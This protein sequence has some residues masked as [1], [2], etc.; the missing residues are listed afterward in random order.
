[1]LDTVAAV[2]TLKGFHA[3]NLNGSN[4]CMQGTHLTKAKTST[5][6]SQRTMFSFLHRLG[7]LELQ[8]YKRYAACCLGAVLS[9]PPG[10]ASVKLLSPR[11]PASL[12]TYL[13]HLDDS[14]DGSR[15]F[16]Y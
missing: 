3:C 8:D 15:L 10:W 14:N 13:E 5:C 2:L 1:M 16:D 11:L 7:W 9:A 12:F 6:P 4:N